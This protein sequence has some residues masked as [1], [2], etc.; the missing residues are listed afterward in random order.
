M[1]ADHIKS[2]NP[3]R[4]G[5]T[6]FSVG[7]LYT[8]LKAFQ[9]QLSN[10]EKPLYFV[11]VDVKAAF[12]TIP[13]SS[14]IKLMSTVATKSDYRISKHVE[15]KP[16]ENYREDIPGKQKSKPTRKWAALAKGANDPTT[17]KD[18]L[19]TNLA[20]GK[21]NAIFVDTVVNQYRGADELLN[22]LTE[23]ISQN[24]VKIGK[25]F[26]RQKQGIP[27]GSVL[28]SLLCN[29][30]YADLETTHFS[31]LQHEGSLLLRLIDDFLLITTDHSHAKQFLQIMHDGVPDY[32]V[33][34]N[35]TKTLTNFEVMI[36][37]QK[38]T[39]V[40]GTRQFPYC[41]TFIDVKTLDISRDR[42]RRKDLGM[43][44]FIYFGYAA[45]LSGSKGG[46]VLVHCADFG[47]AIVDSLTVEFSK[48]PGRS[49]H[50]K[51]LSESTLFS[52]S[53]YFGVALAL[54]LSTNTVVA[55][56]NAGTRMLV[57][58]VGQQHLRL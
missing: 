44:I 49:F 8:K 32:G 56:R 27:Q 17:F 52:F 37:G 57:N 10:N 58:Q 24:M 33:N 13:Q 48:T 25:K 15:I 42:E 41:G 20:V 34:V 51:V 4:L 6:L 31:F 12:D 9:T 55:T 30:F 18:N 1:K 5:S 35:P 22:L 39:R 38:V 26:Y 54:L 50:R 46:L 16:G 40:V 14:V 53:L 28:S 21:K 29:Y 2:T 45:L 11:K 43:L 3:S 7:D 36:N 19:E 23:H 47:K